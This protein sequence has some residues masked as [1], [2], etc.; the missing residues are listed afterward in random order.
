VRVLG[1]GCQN[2]LRLHHGKGIA[3]ALP[4]P[5]PEGEIGKAWATNRALGGE[6]FRVLPK[7]G[8]TVSAVRHQED[9][10]LGRDMIAS[11]L[12][13]GDGVTREAKSW[14]VEPQRFP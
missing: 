3:N 10:A 8:M 7:R 11:N 2:E 4:W 5:A 12:V 14:W 6:A 13:I 9:D 1:N